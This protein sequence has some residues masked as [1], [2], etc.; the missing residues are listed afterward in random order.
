[1]VS[2]WLVM[3]AGANRRIKRVT[4]HYMAAGVVQA[5]STTEFSGDFT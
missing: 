4:F 5:L 2:S 3:M 1:M